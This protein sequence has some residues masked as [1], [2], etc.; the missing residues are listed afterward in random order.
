MS[1]DSGGASPYKAA[2][3]NIRDTVKWLAAALASLAAV[4]IGGTQFS[5]IGTIPIASR[6]FL[7]AAGILLLGFACV[8]VA[9][10]RTVQLLR[11]DG[12]YI[13]DLLRTSLD[14]SDD[15][16]L[17]Q[18]RTEIDAHHRDWLPYNYPTIERLVEARN[19]AQQSMQ[20]AVD[21]QDREAFKLQ[22]E[23]FNGLD[24][25]TGNVLDFALYSRL[26]YRVKNEM[27]V[28][29]AIAALALLLLLSFSAIIAQAKG[30]DSADAPPA[31]TTI[32]EHS[33]ATSCD[34]PPAPEPSLAPVKFQTGR[35]EVDRAGLTAIASVRDYLHAHPDVVVLLLAHTDTVGPPPVNEPLARRRGE[36]VRTLLLDP[37]GIAAAR[38]FVAELPEHSL[39]VVTNQQ[40]PEDRNRS[41]EFVIAAVTPAKSQTE[42][43]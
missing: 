39:P 40:A 33:C 14:A 38:V 37:G 24:A 35:A 9:L 10:Y 15:K 1:E 32:I 42:P 41:V 20:L 21:Q 22:Q 27:P 26:Y 23:V 29:F 17:R 16:A 4:V 3:E 36:A 18:V 43:E 34:K 13:S 31:E 2:Q 25:A 5:G 7:I 12:I 30:E 11:S 19:N 8:A 28:L 6:L